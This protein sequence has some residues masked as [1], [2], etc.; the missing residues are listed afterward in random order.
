MHTC[1]NQR[2]FCSTDC[3]HTWLQKSGHDRGYVMDLGTLWR[4]ADDWYTERLGPGY[5]RRDPTS[6]TAY[7]AK[8]GLHG[9]FWGL[10]DW[11][12]CTCHLAGPEPAWRPPPGRLAGFGEQ[13]IEY[14]P[15]TALP[16]CTITDGL[17]RS[18]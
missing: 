14:E 13:R 12:G 3:V 6:A 15:P 18:T 5:T 11:S 2:L 17:T 10:P 1:A 4:F 16:P 8:V 7:F 9:S